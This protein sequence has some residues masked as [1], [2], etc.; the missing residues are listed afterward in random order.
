MSTGPR[1]LFTKEQAE[2][3]KPSIAGNFTVTDANTGKPLFKS[4]LMPKPARQVGVFTPPP[5]A[6]TVPAPIE[7]KPHSPAPLFQSTQTTELDVTIEDKAKFKEFDTR[8]IMKIKDAA[9]TIDLTSR[10][11][12]IQYGQELNKKLATAVDEILSFVKG[13]AF[14][15][16]VSADV[17]KLHSL[18]NFNPAVEE[19]PGFLG[20][21]KKKKTLSE[22]I[23]EVIDAVESVSSS[24]EQNITHFLALIPKIDSLLDGS[25]NYHSELLILIAAG[26]DRI[27]VFKR[28]RLPRINEKLAGTNMMEAQNARDE[29]DIFNSFV[30]RVE[31]LGLTLD[32]NELTLAQIRLTQTTNVKMVESLNNVITNLVPMWKHS[33]ISSITTNNFDNVNKNKDLLSQ[34]IND[35]MSAKSGT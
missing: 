18:V 29:L 8:A 6:A 15:E 13:T 33:L 14:D 23:N 3:M 1:P 20:L 11:G 22:R 5:V 31:T 26:K 35:I 2:N 24:V 28:R 34:S 12:V 16:K 7:K 4:D 10:A 17:G 30:K 32:Q 25:K 9:E 27:E 19:D 21:F